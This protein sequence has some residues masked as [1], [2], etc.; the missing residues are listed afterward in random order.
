VRPRGEWSG[1]SEVGEVVGW[2]IGEVMMSEEAL[3]GGTGGMSVHG[4]AWS[5]DA[6]W[7]GRPLAQI[8]RSRAVRCPFTRVVTIL[9]YDPAPVVR[10]NGEIQRRRCSY[11]P[12][13]GCR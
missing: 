12:V 2:M 3:S 13:R 5:G 11:T 10:I 1:A 6:G 9:P 7:E 8:G 4:V